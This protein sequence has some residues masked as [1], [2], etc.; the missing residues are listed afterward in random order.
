MKLFQFK[1]WPIYIAYKDII[2][3]F[4]FKKNVSE[5]IKNPNSK[6]NKLNLKRNWLGN[7]IYTQV[8]LDDNLDLMPPDDKMIVLMDKLKP[9]HEYFSNDLMVSEYITP[10]FNN[11]VDDEGHP[12]LSYGILYIFTPYKFSVIWLLKWLLILGV[13]IFIIIKYLIPLI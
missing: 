8:S 2:N 10:N 5:D 11:F 3:F 9:V 13:I 12:T 4:I 7:I 6:F 1:T